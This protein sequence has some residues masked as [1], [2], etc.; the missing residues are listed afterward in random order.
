MFQC[1]LAFLSSSFILERVNSTSFVSFT[2]QSVSG[3][4]TCGDKQSQFQFSGF[5]METISPG[6][7]LT[8]KGVTFVSANDPKIEEKQVVSVFKGNVSFSADMSALNTSL[9]ASLSDFNYIDFNALVKGGEELK[10]MAPWEP[11]LGRA[12][13]AWMTLGVILAVIV[14][15]TGVMYLCRRR[16]FRTVVGALMEDERFHLHQ[17]DQPDES[18]AR[19]ANDLVSRFSRLRREEAAREAENEESQEEG[20]APESS[21]TPGAA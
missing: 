13:I 12:W 19:A 18:L 6:C 2:N 8:V 20:P 21:E 9:T 11:T 7:V 15:L 4:V 5:Q 14:G 1:S 17:P 3:I 10:N 16:L